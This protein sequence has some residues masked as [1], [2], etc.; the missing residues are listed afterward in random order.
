MAKADV[1]RLSLPRDFRIVTGTALDPLALAELRA[2]AMR[3]SLE[4]AGRFDPDRVRRRFLDHFDAEATAAFYAGQDLAGFIVVRQMP[5]HL[6]LDH[7]YVAPDQQG[8][9]LGAQIIRSV[10]EQMAEPTGQE[11]RLIALT[12][13]PA[14]RFYQR[15]GFER[16]GSDGIDD[17]Y[18]WHPMSRD[19]RGNLG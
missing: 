19:S 18:S 7:L 10:Q 15:A 16:T 11:I 12:G 6:Y 9:G 14:G 4:A 5:D 3:P 8:A 2:K 17:S 13:S 1:T